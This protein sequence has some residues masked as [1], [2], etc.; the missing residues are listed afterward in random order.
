MARVEIDLVGVP[1]GAGVSV[2]F[3]EN[4]ECRRPHVILHHPDGKPMAHFVMPDGVH[5]RNFL[6]NLQ[7]AMYR[8]IVERDGNAG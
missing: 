4:P 3:C 5:G 7:D 6:K 1:Q 8:S 2:A